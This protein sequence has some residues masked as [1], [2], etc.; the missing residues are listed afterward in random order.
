MGAP[1]FIYIGKVNKSN[2]VK[3]GA[4]LLSTTIR[5]ITVVK[6]LWTHEV[7]LKTTTRI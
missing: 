3:R 2:V 6:M 1:P 4:A 5:V 7:Q